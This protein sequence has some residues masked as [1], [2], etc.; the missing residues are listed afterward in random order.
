MSLAAQTI[1]YYPAW[2]ERWTVVG[3][4]TRKLQGSS[5]QS[6]ATVANAYFLTLSM[7]NKGFG[8]VPIGFGITT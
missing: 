3:L 2:L 7:P 6:I 4:S 1:I 8:I 5:N